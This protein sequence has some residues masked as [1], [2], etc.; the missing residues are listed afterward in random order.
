MAQLKRHPR[1]EIF[2]QEVAKGVPPAEAYIAAGFD[3]TGKR[4]RNHNRLLK[5]ADVVAR[6]DELKAMREA[7]A[8]SAHVAPDQV[9]ET[10]DRCGVVRVGDFFERDGAG[11]VRLRNLDR[12]PV[13][14]AIAFLRF[15]R[16]STKIEQPV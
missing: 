10:L 7:A 6:I 9:I 14:I 4:C 1:Y 2:A 15:V 11:I 12:V 13:E 5:R 3:Q 8:R 16:A